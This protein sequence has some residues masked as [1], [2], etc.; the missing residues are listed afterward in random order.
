MP[1]IHPTAIVDD[2]VEMAEDV[3]IGP[4]SILEGRMK[5]GSGTRIR[6]HAFMQGPL[7]M[8]ESNEVWPFAC[9]GSAPQTSHFDPDSEGPGTVIGD[10]N[11]F[12]EHS[13]IHRSIHET[14]PTRIGNH[15]LFMDSAHAGHDCIIGDHVIMSKGAALG[16]HVTLENNV[17]VGGGAMIHQFCRI[18][19]GAMLGGLVGM[20]RDLMPWFTA[21]AMNMAA[22][23]NTIG[24]KRN[25]HSSEDVNIARWVYRTICRSNLTIE[26]A[27]QQLETEREH[28]LVAEYLTFMERSN[29]PICTASG[30]IMPRERGS[31]LST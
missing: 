21:T 28:P 23:I 15:N 17:I 30:R 20:S 4:Y 24:M 22:T 3:E 27:R 26:Q 12:R 6:S 16:G 31:Q 11:I 13:S 7:V 18:G 2:R 1:R 19:R 29:R 10:H 9:I 8:G 25:G 14:E 5:L